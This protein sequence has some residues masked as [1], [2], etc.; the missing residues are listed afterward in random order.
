MAV[1][2]IVFFFLI[3]SSFFQK[4]N[5]GSSQPAVDSSVAAM[6]VP[7]C[8]KPGPHMRRV[9]WGKSG[10]Q[11]DVPTREVQVLGGKPDVDYVSYVIKPKTG[12]GYLEFW[13]G[14]YAFSSTPNAELLGN[15]VVTQ[16]REIV[17]A[18]GKGIGVDRSG[19]LR[20]GEVWRH[21][22]FGILGMDGARYKSSPE[23]AAIFDRIIDS[24]CNVPSPRNER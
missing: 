12:V 24:A 4:S 14:P 17:S 13:F 6:I 21:T 19:K 23:N 9:G 16:E 10:L 20:T 3:F 22:F 15:S 8:A 11:F 18:D 2:S 7:V 5:V 1:Y